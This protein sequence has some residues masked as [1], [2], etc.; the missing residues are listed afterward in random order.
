MNHNP[1]ELS[2]ERLRA[3]NTS[4]QSKLFLGGIW[5][6]V[7]SGQTWLATDGKRSVI[8]ADSMTVIY[9]LT[10]AA[11]PGRN[12]KFFIQ[13]SVGFR[14]EVTTY[15]FA[16][17][18]R[19][20]APMARLAQIEMQVMIGIFAVTS[21]F[22][23]AAVI[24]TDLVDFSL[25]NHNNFGKWSKA[26]GACV[27]VR[28]VLKRHAP[29]LYDKLIDGVLIAAG[30]G[31]TESLRNIPEAAVSD[32]KLMGRFIGALVGKLGKQA[33]SSRLSA[34]SVIWILLSTVAT[35]SIGAV[36]GALR[37][38]LDERAKTADAIITEL[39]RGGVIL[40][41]ED[42]R[43]IV[44]EVAAKP[45]EI[46]ASLEQLKSAFDGIRAE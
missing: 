1:V 17:A 41:A 28:E 21:G 44:E 14:G 19:R 6:T 8:S 18:G 27:V 2:A 37:L 25:K 46:R 4:T 26:L 33:L 34:L 31:L 45:Q 13:S 15:S 24:G 20:A 22:G 43:K 3:L 16:E 5:G 39:R 30:V 32:P 7:E 38:S 10:A 23:L 29:T 11:H 42:A 9:V 35:K 12:N 40:S 36:P